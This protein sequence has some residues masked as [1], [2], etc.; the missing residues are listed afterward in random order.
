[1]SD[2]IEIKPRVIEFD[3]HEV[4]FRSCADGGLKVTFDLAGDLASGKAVAMLGLLRMKNLK[5]TVTER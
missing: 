3:A 2:D 5:I 4:N 1:M